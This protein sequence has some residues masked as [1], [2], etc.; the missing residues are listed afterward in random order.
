[1]ISEVSP[2][3]RGA[4]K[5]VISGFALM[6]AFL[7]VLTAIPLS[8]V[9][10]EMAKATK[11]GGVG[12]GAGWGILLVVGAPSFLLM[13]GIAGAL[14]EAGLERFGV[15]SRF[16]QGAMAGGIFA[17]ILALAPALAKVVPQNL[18]TMGLSLSMMFDGPAGLA[19]AALI[20]AVTFA[21]GEP[22]QR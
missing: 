12:S 9:S 20:A 7:I 3:W 13:T 2:A 17:A 14:V 6:V 11:N 5:G 19:A 22:P 18:L 4:L 16:L 21:M 8:L 10:P 1:M 15:R